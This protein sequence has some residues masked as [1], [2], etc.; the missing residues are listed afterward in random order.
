VDLCVCTCIRADIFYVNVHDFPARIVP[1]WAPAVQ[2][3][4]VGSYSQSAAEEGGSCCQSA[5]EEGGSCSQS[6]A[7]E[8]GS[9]SQSA[10]EGSEGVAIEPGQARGVAAVASDEEEFTRSSGSGRR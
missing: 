4:E 9:Y 1:S 10:A 2:R 8:G 3:Q 6:V 5:A 7:D